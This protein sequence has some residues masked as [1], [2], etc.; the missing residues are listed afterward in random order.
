[1]E[2]LSQPDY[3]DGKVIQLPD[4]GGV[5]HLEENGT[6]HVCAVTAEVRERLR[7][8]VNGP[9]I[10]GFGTAEWLRKPEGQWE[11]KAFSIESFT[12]LDDKPLDQV[13]K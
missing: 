4:A 13:L 3:L 12:P 11:L 7:P 6:T 5:V 9:T 10:R 2:P 1:M 8:Y